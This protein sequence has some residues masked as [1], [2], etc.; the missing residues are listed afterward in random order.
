MIKFLLSSLFF[1]LSI[2]CFSQNITFTDAN[3]KT[4]LLTH[5]P[6]IDT[7]SD[8]EISVSEASA[9]NGDLFVSSANSAPDNEK[10]AD[11]NGIEFFTNITKLYCSGNNLTELSLTQNT[12]LESI[13]AF[14]NQ[15]V[16]IDV[17]QNALVD[18]LWVHENQLTSLDVSQNPLLDYLRCRYNQITSLD[19]SQNP[20]LYQLSCADNQLTSID[21]TQCPILELFDCAR[22]Q[23]TSID[24]SQNPDLFGFLCSSNLFTNIDISLNPNLTGFIVSDN[25]FLENINMRNGGNENLLVPTQFGFAAVDCP[26]LQT[27]CVDDS[28]FAN[29]FFTEVSPLAIFV[30][31]CLADPIYNE[32]EGKVTVDFDLDG[33]DSGDITYQN[34]LVRV[35]NS[36]DNF[37]STYTNS[38]GLYNHLVTEGDY[39]TFL[40]TLPSYFVSDPYL[41]SASF[42]DLGNTEVIDFCV[43]PNAVVDDLNVVLIPINEA[44]PGFD[45]SYE[46]VYQN[47]GT[48]VISG[49][50]SLTFDDSKQSF[51]SSIPSEDSS[52]S[53]NVNYDYINLQPLETRSV[54]ITMNT[55]TPPTVNGDDVLA[56]T[57][58]IEPMASDNTPED[59]SYEFAQ[60]VVN[61]Y[62]PNDI[63]C[64][65]GAEI[66]Q[67]QA[68]GYL[69][70][71][72]RFQNTG[73]ASAINVEITHELDEKFNQNTLLPIASSHDFT[74][75]VTTSRSV[76]FVFENI[77]LPAQ[78]DDDAGSNG[79]VAFKIKPLNNVVVGD[80]FNAQASIYFDFNLP[81]ITNIASTEIVDTLTNSEFTFN[82]NSIKLYPNPTNKTF[83]LKTSNEL[84]VKMVSVFSLKGELLFESFSK[85]DIYNIEYL[86]SGV[87]L[88]KI[89]TNKG[90]FN[91]RLLKN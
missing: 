4:K 41:Q 51:V 66:L 46:L 40:F 77:N 1:C 80:V 73:T 52:T 26:N 60:I 58:N 55:F 69:V 68:D 3:F 65:Q 39:N 88:L 32:I 56:F 72:I 62:D 43:T 71:K 6:V 36:D 81:I 44:R 15:L 30:E 27:I 8:G 18:T 28:T 24:V 34:L 76:E 38:D 23:L 12:Q 19:L 13:I 21:V 7:N 11:L 53:N 49:S 57:A 86:S 16:S 20:L 33:C 79:F 83:L 14:S 87:Y 61:S 67:E 78:Q 84:Q 5:N 54:I 31:D 2:T 82:N 35:Y 59:N 91:K 74:T 9:F 45:A 42:S 85:N 50:V 17:S 47:V 63:T 90:V 64:M 70:Y 10:I 22:N 29:N 48:T 37:F 89:T 25:Y 75:R